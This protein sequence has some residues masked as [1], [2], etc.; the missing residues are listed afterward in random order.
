MTQ[1]SSFKPTPQSSHMVGC[2][3]APAKEGLPADTSV[4]SGEEC[5]DEA[6]GILQKLW[7]E[8]CFC[9]GG[10]C[11]NGVGDTGVDEAGRE[12]ML[13]CCGEDC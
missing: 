4:E 11:E 12:A 8:D 10:T 2:S 13:S 3:T 7:R 9:I 1:S 5:D 6:V